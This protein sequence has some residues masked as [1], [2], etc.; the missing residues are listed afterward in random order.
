MGPS[1]GFCAIILKLTC[2]RTHTHLIE[3]PY[4]YKPYSTHVDILCCSFHIAYGAGLLSSFGELDYCL[5]DKPEVRWI[6]YVHGMSAHMHCQCVFDDPLSCFDRRVCVYRCDRSTALRPA[7]SLTP[8]Q[9]TSSCS[10]VHKLKTHTSSTHDHDRYQ[11]VYWLAE[12][13]GDMKAKIR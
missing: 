5:S 8:L 11:P 13:F 9:S 2:N 6:A 1:A 10:L 7:T 12:S 3:D 4:E